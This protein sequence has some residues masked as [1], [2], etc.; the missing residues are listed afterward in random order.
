[1][2]QLL[3]IVVA[4]P[5]E[6]SR[7]LISRVVAQHGAARVVAEV[8]RD[9]SLVDA[10]AYRRPHLAFVATE[11]SGMRGFEV[12]DQLSRR[13][14][15]LYIA[16]I[17]PRSNDVNDLR[18]AMKAGAR[19]C[20][21]EP[22]SD[23]A[24]RRVIDEAQQVGEAVSERRGAVIAVM[25]SKGGVGK[26]TIAVNLA[27][28]LKQL[29]AGRL[30]LVDGDLY[31]GD[32]A[33]LLNIKPERTIHDLNEALDAEIADKFLYKHSS[34]IEVLAAP[35]RTEQAEAITPERLRAMIGV[36]QTLYD[37]VVVDVT[38]NA[39]DLVLATLDV[40]DLAIVLATLDVV[41]L[42]DVSQIVDVLNKLRFP[43]RNVILL[44]NRHDERFSLSPKDAERAM[45]LR[46]A[47]VVP[48]DDRVMLAANQGVPYILAEPG[49]P[50][51]QKV[52]S[53]AK[54]IGDRIGR[55]DR[56]PA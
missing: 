10:V 28:A 54:M 26:S 47:A 6:A 46:F 5:E 56:V 4:A 55:I 16:M 19:E 23:Q 52:R 44:G 48:R 29:G 18:Q 51:T 43:T 33:T 21:Y 40:A 41:C 49:A 27:I 45:G 36:L 14:P 22:L 35:V 3:R 15:G 8:D 38:V 31:F 53:L 20:L 1:M 17:S 13:H 37:V 24:V 2:S 25:S 42:K 50:F 9:D 32:L 11:L 34:G 39:L 12:A 30:A 7:N